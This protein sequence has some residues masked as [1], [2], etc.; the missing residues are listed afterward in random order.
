MRFVGLLIYGF[1]AAACV[2]E[3]GFGKR[4]GCTR[5]SLLLIVNANNRACQVPVGSQNSW[6]SDT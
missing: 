3:V 4:L 5:E 1:L 6:A 2:N